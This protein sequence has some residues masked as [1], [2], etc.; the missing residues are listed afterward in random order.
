MN[1]EDVIWN[2]IGIIL[3]CVLLSIICYIV[4]EFGRIAFRLDETQPIITQPTEPEYTESEQNYIRINK[5][6]VELCLHLH[7]D[8]FDYPT[9]RHRLQQECIDGIMEIS[10]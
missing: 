9:E 4:I 6:A 10:K 8:P 3:L 1:F 7:N 5:L 2:I